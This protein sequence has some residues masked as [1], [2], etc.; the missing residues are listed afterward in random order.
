MSLIESVK[1]CVWLC[2]MVD[3]LG[4][5][6]QQPIIYCDSQSVLDLARN[7]AYHEKIKH[8]DIRLYF[9]R[10][11]IENKVFAVEKI[12]TTENPADMLTKA[13]PYAKF[14]LSLHL[15]NVRKLW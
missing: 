12:T 3:S 13:L 4:L 2:G 15:V 6:V 10:D 11:M 7:P 14:K 8:M 1:E 9:I 5:I